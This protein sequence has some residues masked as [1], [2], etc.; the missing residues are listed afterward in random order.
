MWTSGRTTPLKELAL[1]TI[2]VDGPFELE[3]T[4]PCPAKSVVFTDVWFQAPLEY[5]DLFPRSECLVWKHTTSGCLIKPTSNLKYNTPSNSL[6]HLELSWYSDHCPLDG[7][8]GVLMSPNLSSLHLRQLH[9]P[10]REILQDASRYLTA[11]PGQNMPSLQEMRIDGQKLEGAADPQEL[12][13]EM[14][15]DP[16]FCPKLS[17]TPVQDL[18]EGSLALFLRKSM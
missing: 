15:E 2:N 17:R 4:L 11:L 16:S 13:R 12:L 18:P 8:K 1:S 3:I 5:S 6:K 14:L 9:I 7:K 10:P